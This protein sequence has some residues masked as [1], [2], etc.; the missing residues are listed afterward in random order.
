M[1][2]A[3]GLCMLLLLFAS[4]ELHSQSVHFGPELGIYNATDADGSRLMGG[5]A[6]RIRMSRLFGIEGSVNYRREDYAGGN[7]TATSWPVM[8]TALL[9]P[10]PIVYG[11]VGAGWYNTAI[12]Y[13]NGIFGAP[14]YSVTDTK[15]DFGWH[16]GGGVDL[17]V[18]GYTRL[19]G[20]IRYVFLDYGFRE[21]PGSSGINANFYIV[22]IGL[23]FRI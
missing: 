23:L 12:D 20:D 4:S 2:T 6:L 3:F 13:H 18:G 8:V 11:A 17:P 10:L 16:F 14:G 7:V 1:K 19:V 15:Q 9:Y 5:I 21:F 22:T